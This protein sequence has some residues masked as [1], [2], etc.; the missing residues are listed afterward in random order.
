[1]AD[2]W[3]IVPEI[4]SGEMTDEY[5]PKYEADVDGYVTHSIPG[6]DR[7]IVRFYA[8][9]TTLDDIADQDDTKSLSSTEVRN[10]LNDMFD[11]NRSYDEWAE[12]IYSAY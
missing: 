10:H 3:F 9:E 11:A 12:L 5:R 7:F 6:T 1:M 8:D 4:G 2:R